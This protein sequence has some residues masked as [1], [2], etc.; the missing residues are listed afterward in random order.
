MNDDVYEHLVA[1]YESAEP[2]SSTRI[3]AHL[4]L[5]LLAELDNPDRACELITFVGEKFRV[6]KD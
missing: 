6:K 5:L 4:I 2:E 1:I 3:D